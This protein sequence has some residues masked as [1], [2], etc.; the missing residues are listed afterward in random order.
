MNE[1]KIEDVLSNIYNLYSGDD[2][3]KKE[4]SSKYLSELQ[5]SVSDIILS[6][7]LN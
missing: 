1:P 6:S 7:N 2:V 4:E 5:S 3:G